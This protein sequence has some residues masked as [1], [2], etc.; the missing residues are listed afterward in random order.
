[1]QTSPQAAFSQFPA[2]SGRMTQPTRSEDLAYQVMTVAAIL[3]LL[4]SVWVF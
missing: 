3:M 2:D 1:M 4:G